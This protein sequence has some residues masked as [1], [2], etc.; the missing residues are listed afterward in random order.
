YNSPNR[1]F[2]TVDSLAFSWVTAARRNT[3]ERK[4]GGSVLAIFG[5]NT[6][7]CVS[8]GEVPPTPEHCGVD[9]VTVAY[10]SHVICAAKATPGGAAS[11]RDT[12]LAIAANRGARTAFVLVIFSI[13]LLSRI[14]FIIRTYY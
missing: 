14:S 3:K 7:T 12:P 6:E 10:P 4:V 1:S 8:P 13:S 5:R 11:A 9:A 2:G